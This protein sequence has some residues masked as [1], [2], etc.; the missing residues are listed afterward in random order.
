[1]NAGLIVIATHGYTGFKHAF[2]GSTAERVVRHSSCPVL[3][4]RQ[5]GQRPKRGKIRLRNILVPTDFSTCGRIGFECGVELAREFQ[6]KLALVHV[7]DP[8]SYPF[9]D[10]YAALDSAHLMEEARALAQTEMNQMTARV[11]VRTSIRIAEGSP[12]TV[13]CDVATKD[14]DL[15]VISTHGR[16]GLGHVLIGSVAEHVVRRS[17]CPVLVIPARDK[18]KK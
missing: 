5:E 10:E 4:V 1:V 14:A 11:D 7:I 13:I 6:A 15:I 18:L 12:A 2:V 16:T 9:G 17:S 8:F 3:V